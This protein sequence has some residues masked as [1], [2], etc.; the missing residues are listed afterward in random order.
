MRIKTIETFI[1]F[2]LATTTMANITTL[3]V[4]KTQ[5]ELNPNKIKTLTWNIHG[6]KAKDFKR[7]FKRLTKNIYE[8]S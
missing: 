7:D 8:R 4:G 3:Q 5:N 1:L 2:I 6:A